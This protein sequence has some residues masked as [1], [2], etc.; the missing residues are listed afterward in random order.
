[1]LHIC[2]YGALLRSA[3]AA[4]SAISA[5]SNDKAKFSAF[6]SVAGPSAGIPGV[7]GTSLSVDRVSSIMQSAT[8]GL[9][10]AT[11]FGNY[12]YDK[13]FPAISISAI[14]QFRQH[15]PRTSDRVEAANQRHMFHVQQH[16]S[17]WSLLNGDYEVKG[18]IIDDEQDKPTGCMRAPASARRLYHRD[19]IT[20]HPRSRRHV[21]RRTAAAWVD[22]NSVPRSTD[23]STTA[24]GTSDELEFDAVDPGD[25]MAVRVWL[26]FRCVSPEVKPA[27]SQS[28]GVT[29]NVTD[30]NDADLTGPTAQNDPRRASATTASIPREPTEV[31]ASSI[32]SHLSTN[33]DHHGLRSS[34]IKAGP[35]R[36]VPWH[37]CEAIILPFVR[38]SGPFDDT[39]PPRSRR[40]SAFRDQLPQQHQHLFCCAP[41]VYLLKA[42]YCSHRRDAYLCGSHF[43]I[44]RKDDAVESNNVSQAANGLDTVTPVDIS[45][46]SL[47]ECRASARRAACEALL[48]ALTPT[49]TYCWLSVKACETNDSRRPLQ[50]VTEFRSGPDDSASHVGWSQAT[51]HPALQSEELVR[52]FTS[53]SA[54]QSHNTVSK[55]L[56][57]SFGHVQLT[58]ASVWDDFI[59]AGSGKIRVCSASS[60]FFVSLHNWRHHVANLPTPKVSIDTD[61]DFTMGEYDDVLVAVRVVDCAD[62]DAE[63]VR[64]INAVDRSWFS[65]RVTALHHQLVDATD[66]IFANAVDARLAELETQQA[67]DDIPSVKKLSSIVGALGG[68]CDYRSVKTRLQTKFP[69]GF[70]QMQKHLLRQRLE[71]LLAACLSAR[72]VQDLHLAQLQQRADGSRTFG[73]GDGSGSGVLVPER[74]TDPVVAVLTAV[75]NQARVLFYSAASGAKRNFSV[76]DTVKEIRQKLDV[77]TPLTDFESVAVFHFVLKAGWEYG[78]CK[79]IGHGSHGRGHC[80][81]LQVSTRDMPLLLRATDWTN[82]HQVVVTLEALRNCQRL[83]KE[84]LPLSHHPQEASDGAKPARTKPTLAEVLQLLHPAHAGCTLA[85]EYGKERL[86]ALALTPDQ[87]SCILPQLVHSFRWE[88]MT[89]LHVPST[90]ASRVNVSTAFISPASS[91]PQFCVGRAAYSSAEMS[92][93][94]MASSVTHRAYN[95]LHLHLL[96][97]AVNISHQSTSA[98]STVGLVLFWL[99][100]VETSARDDSLQNAGIRTVEHRAFC[101]HL[102]QTLMHSMTPDGQ[103]QAGGNR[104]NQQNI[105]TTSPSNSASTTSLRA[106]FEDQRRLWGEHGLFADVND[107]VQRGGYPETGDKSYVVGEIDG[108]DN[109]IVGSRGGVDADLLRQLLLG[110]LT[111]NTDRF[112]L[113]N[114][115]LGPN[116]GVVFSCGRYSRG[117]DHELSLLLQ[118]AKH[119][120]HPML[121][122]PLHPAWMPRSTMLLHDL[123]QENYSTLEAIGQRYSVAV[124][125][126]S[127]TPFKSLPDDESCRDVFDTHHFNEIPNV[128]K[129]AVGGVQQPIPNTTS[130][131]TRHD[132][133]IRVAST[134]EKSPSKAPLPSTVKRTTV[135][136]PSTVSITSSQ[137][138]TPKTQGPT[139]NKGRTKQLIAANPFEPESQVQ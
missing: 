89:L 1:M 125:S 53:L 75:A 2:R 128:H 54:E 105:A 61:S 134:V 50:V 86:E 28:V 39:R 67:E 31:S 104:T 14:Q 15:Q 44:K 70:L 110:G 10:H 108:T 4:A 107:V 59:V 20:G 7:A 83:D 74:N 80:V 120:G 12:L 106:M 65:W 18:G 66:A 23:A 47:H 5:G 92:A 129:L 82:P 19:A 126:G 114:R 136:Q 34:T 132:D 135:S 133:S 79:P 103:S 93:E 81:N 40:G 130:R 100:Q 60:I 33:L 8:A 101:N 131:A 113:R 111:G 36:A 56:G 97:R 6:L 71:A 90:S 37:H 32:E 26:H 72:T 52:A 30:K 119:H 122:R 22:S 116:L 48:A 64:W 68:A 84:S 43:A 117:Q 78:P 45:G 109:V 96:L 63:R 38:K 138:K 13:A 123:S 112:E 49:Q 58:R 16:L 127:P 124:G 57:L 24:V 76:D 87:L 41:A 95:S 11:A 118:R 27:V 25:P 35:V 42:E 9:P 55:N 69:L 139:R 137:K 98:G 3:D 121:L 73:G 91:T 102:L 62:V 115:S 17:S 99:L 21:L 46:R 88:S 94:Q 29:A 77:L 51:P 85:R